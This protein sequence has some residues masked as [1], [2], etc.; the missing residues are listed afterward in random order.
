MRRRPAGRVGNGIMAEAPMEAEV[1]E[2]IP[3]PDAVTDPE[4]EPSAEAAPSAPP[5]QPAA[6]PVVF[7]DHYLIDTNTPLPDLDTP[8]AKAYAVEDRRDLGRKLFGLVCTPG[9]PTRIDAMNAL[10]GEELEGLLPLVEWD[11]LDWPLLGQHTMIV[12]Y[13]LPRGGKVMSAMEAG[14]F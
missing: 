9:L 6:G 11:T 7:R 8:S 1:G 4:A 12:I 2:E 10:K 5:V 13:H 14:T 3:P